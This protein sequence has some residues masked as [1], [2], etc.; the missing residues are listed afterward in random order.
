MQLA[1]CDQTR[2]ARELIFDMDTNMT[3]INAYAKKIDVCLS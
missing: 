2:R 3:T 1:A